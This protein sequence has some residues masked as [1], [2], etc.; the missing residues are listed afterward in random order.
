MFS[1]TL[2]QSPPSRPFVPDSHEDLLGSPERPGHPRARKPFLVRWLGRRRRRRFIYATLVAVSALPFLLFYFPAL[3]F[4]RSG[5]FLKVVWPLTLPPLYAASRARE[6]ALPQ[7]LTV[8]PFAGGRKFL[9]I[10]GHDWGACLSL[11]LWTLNTD[12]TDAFMIGYGWGNIMQEI[13][14]NAHLSYVTGRAYAVWSR[15]PYRVLR[16]YSC[17]TI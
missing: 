4:W 10:A 17:R 13:V 14:M 12:V 15:L 11:S 8:D 5:H 1:N 9:W 16:M 2:P 3:Q 6:A 7:H